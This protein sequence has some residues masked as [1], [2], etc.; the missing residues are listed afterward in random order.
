M[1]TNREIVGTILIG[2]SHYSRQVKLQVNTLGAAV[3][4]VFF[5]RFIQC[6]RSVYA[7]DNMQMNL[8]NLLNWFLSI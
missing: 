4:A 6:S 3:V 2:D 8:F 1:C 5:S 7:C